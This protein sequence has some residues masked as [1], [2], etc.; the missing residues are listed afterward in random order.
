MSS[1]GRGALRGA[2]VQWPQGARGQPP[3]RPTG[4]PRRPEPGEGPEED[5]EREND[6]KQ[7]EHAAAGR[8]ATP[9]SSSIELSCGRAAP[10]KVN[11]LI[12]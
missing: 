12:V 3:E 9:G 11:I 2:A 6:A 8:A 5:R 1:L 10:A 4:D 7:S